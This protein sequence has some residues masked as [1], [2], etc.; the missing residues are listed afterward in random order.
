M[1]FWYLVN[2]CQAMETTFPLGIHKHLLNLGINETQVR[3]LESIY[4][5]KN[6]S[7]KDI[8]FRTELPKSTIIYSLNRL[9]ELHLVRSHRDGLKEYY[10]LESYEHLEHALKRRSQEEIEHIQGKYEHIKHFWQE[11]TSPHTLPHLRIY[12]GNENITAIYQDILA[13]MDIQVLLLNTYNLHSPQ[14]LTR[15]HIH[16]LILQPQLSSERQL[17]LYRNRIACIENREG[18]AFGYIL[19]NGGIGEMLREMVEK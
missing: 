6:P 14:I 13:H 2:N 15:T 19:E 8:Q 18:K 3:I 10:S 9:K 1:L 12:Q 4:V 11:C 17:F 16:A 5:L 7:T